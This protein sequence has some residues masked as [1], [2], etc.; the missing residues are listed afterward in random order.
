MPDFIARIEL[1]NIKASDPSY[2]KLH[3]ALGDAKLYQFR[4]FD[5]VTLELPTGTYRTSAYSG[6]EAVAKAIASAV[7]TA[8]PN[9]KY[10]VLIS[11]E[12]CIQFGLKKN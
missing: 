4:S 8:A 9:E 10:G 1:F 2:E 5:G 6:P 11:S 3:D 7:A 12:P